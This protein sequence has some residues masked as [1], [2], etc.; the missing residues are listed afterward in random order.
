MRY[1]HFVHPILIYKLYWE[2]LDHNKT[3]VNVL[4]FIMTRFGWLGH[5]QVIQKTKY[6]EFYLVIFSRRLNSVKFFRA[7]SRVKIF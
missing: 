7:S 6:L 3:F 1:F 4:I 5:H 2:K